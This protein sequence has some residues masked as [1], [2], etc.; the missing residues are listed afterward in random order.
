MSS[1]KQRLAE[2]PWADY[3][4]AYGTATDVPL[5][6]E[7][8][9]VGGKAAA[10]PASHDLWCAL[11]HQHVF[12]SSAALPALPFLLEALDGAGSALRVEIL[13]ILLGFARCTSE[14]EPAAV[15]GSEDHQWIRE[16]RARM[17]AER[18]RFERMA[19]RGESDEAEFA[20]DV[21]EELEPR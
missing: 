17:E 4:T 7:R 5:Q 12:L 9:I 14:F 10:M 6:L 1:L 11:C 19:A 15:A 18:P 8:L 13:D 2:V 21:L 16:L 3:E 20:R